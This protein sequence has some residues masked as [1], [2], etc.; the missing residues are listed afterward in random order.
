VVSFS[1]DY[2]IAITPSGILYAAEPGITGN[3]LN[4]VAIVDTN[5]QTLANIILVGNTSASSPTGV[6]ATPDGAQVY[7][8]NAGEGGVSVI[9]TRTQ[10]VTTTLP[11]QTSPAAVAVMP[12]IV[13]TIQTPPASQSV[14]SGDTAT[15][16]VQAS[17]T[18]PLSYQ[19][20]EVTGTT[21]TPIP[22]ANGSSFTT[23]ALTSTTSY[24]VVVSNVVGST[25][26]NTA[27][28]TVVPSTI[29][30]S[31]FSAKL[32]IFSAGFDLKGTFTLGAGGKINPPTQRLTL[33]VG[34][35][36]LTIPAGSFKASPHG[37]FTFE[38]RIKGVAIQIRIAPRGGNSYLI[39]VEASGV[40]LAGL[41]NPVTV[42][43]TI[44]DNAGRTSVNAD[45]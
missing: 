15:L 22:G 25:Q 35:Y 27:T 32:D 40:D 43:L 45:F 44:G 29:I 3:L 4:S 11:V 38:G 9:N 36:T 18:P 12:T 13:P 2:G 19:W 8:S 39:Q 7:V 30:F 6:A 24:A 31:A 34:T 21:L 10:T 1:S 5:T 14:I 42:A 28:V 20:Y 37:T 33:R 41:T 16:S 26:S 17:G 23:P